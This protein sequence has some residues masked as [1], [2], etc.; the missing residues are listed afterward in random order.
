MSFSDILNNIFEQL[1]PFSSGFTFP[2]V[3]SVANSKPEYVKSIVKNNHEIASHG[4]THVKFSFLDRS[5]QQR[6]FQLASESFQKLG[7]EIKGFRAPY[8]NYNDTTLEMV[9]Q[10]GFLWDGG[11]GYQATNREKIHF[12]NPRIKGR[13]LDYTG[14][15]LNWYTDDLLID[16]YNLDSP[17][18]IKALNQEIRRK[19][20]T[21]GVLMFDL[22]PIRIG[23]DRYASIL[24]EI[25]E[26][27]IGLDG[28]APTVS[29]GVQYWQKHQKWKGGAKFCLL[30]TGDIDNFVFLD[31]LRRLV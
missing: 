7:I 1:D 4:Y 22:H 10:F 2:T 21:G 25:L 15:P 29:E 28:W 11:V 9:K 6:E 20:K 23:Q 26:T 12:F 31:Y 13:K 14:I 5:T 19:A 30:L 8:N 3:A 17:Q 16:R 18:I 27:A 24:G